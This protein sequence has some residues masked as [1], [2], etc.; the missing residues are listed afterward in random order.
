MKKYLLIG[1]LNVVLT[2]PLTAQNEGVGDMLMQ[3][4]KMTSVIVVLLIILIGI[5][6]FLTGMDRRI[7][8][9]EQASEET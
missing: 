5:V 1:L 9:I 6:I 8:R 7:R 3:G 2:L 4:G